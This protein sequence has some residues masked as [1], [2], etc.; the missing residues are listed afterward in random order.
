MIFLTFVRLNAPTN[1]GSFK[2]S[3][4]RTFY[5]SSTKSKY[6]YFNIFITFILIHFQNVWKSISV[7]K[8]KLFVPLTGTEKNKL[9]AGKNL[10]NLN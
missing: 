3:Q 6:T 10:L 7:G 1:N 2:G 4:A 9:K 8:T 5:S